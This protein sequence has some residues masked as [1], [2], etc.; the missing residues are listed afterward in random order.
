MRNRRAGCRLGKI[1]MPLSL[2]GVRAVRPCR[3]VTPVQVTCIEACNRGRRYETVND[4]VE[5]KKVLEV[6]T[7]LCLSL[8]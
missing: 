7:I 3:F 4:M 8:K 6:T 2:I 1:S 5:E